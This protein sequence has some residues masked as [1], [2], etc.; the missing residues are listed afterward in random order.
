MIRIT[1]EFYNDNAPESIDMCGKVDQGKSH[2]PATDKKTTP[3][4]PVTSTDGTLSKYEQSVI[5]LPEVRTREQAQAA[6]SALIRQ[7]EAELSNSE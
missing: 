5:S 2:G 6:L 3:D 4:A 1:I 7:A